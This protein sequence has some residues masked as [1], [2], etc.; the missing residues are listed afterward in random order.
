MP[1]SEIR[2]KHLR[3][4]KR[5]V[6]KVGTA[7]LTHEDGSLDARRLKRLTEQVAA[8]RS[9][10]RQVT[11][12]SSGAI[13]AGMGLLS[14]DKRPKDL[15]RLQAVAAVGQAI[16]MRHYEL[17]LSK[18]GLHAAQLLLTRSDFENRVRY[19]NMRNTLSALHEIKAVPIVNENDPVAVDEIR[20]GDNDILAALVANMLHAD[21]LIIL[22]VVDGLLKD[23][24]PIDLVERIDESVQQLASAQTS[25]LGTGGMKSKLEA[26]RMATE[27]GVPAVIA[28]GKTPRILERLMAGEK[29]GTVFAPAERK[30]RARDRWIRMVAKPAGKIFVDAGAAKALVDGRKSLLPIGVVK[31][32]GRFSRGDVVQI[33]APDGSEIGRGLANYSAEELSRIKGL[34]SNKISETLGYA[35]YEEAVHRDNLVITMK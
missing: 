28:N 21:A 20:F 33:I 24:E 9:A 29:L 35:P 34:R 15:P 6:V 26:V 18:H 7:L 17:A 32:S 8:L 11:L 31:V 22:T 2:Q 23:G 5:I 4:A 1:S 10:G 27:A 13:G 30:M 25:R 3:S 14:M 19:L 16:L 12:V